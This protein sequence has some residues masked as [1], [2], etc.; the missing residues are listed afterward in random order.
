MEKMFCALA[1][2]FMI[3]SCSNDVIKNEKQVSNINYP[4]LKLEISDRI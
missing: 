1:M 4:E 2:I 3:T